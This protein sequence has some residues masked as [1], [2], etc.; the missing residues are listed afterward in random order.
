MVGMF[1]ELPRPMVV[2]HH[3]VD[4]LEWHL[5]SKGKLVASAFL[6]AEKKTPVAKAGNFVRVHLLQSF[7]QNVR[8][9]K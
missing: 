3:L 6:K 9:K 1:S 7:L 8:V 2:V 4:V 5:P